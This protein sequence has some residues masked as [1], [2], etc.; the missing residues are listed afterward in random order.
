[1][2]SAQHLSGELGRDGGLRVAASFQQGR[3]AALIGIGEQTNRV[4]Q[5]FEAAQ[6]RPAGDRAQ[7]SQRKVEIARTL[8][9]RRID[10]PQRL[11]RDHEAGEDAGLAQQPLEALMRRGFPAFE[12]A[13]CV[14]IDARRF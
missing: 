7:R 3:Q 9:A 8:A 2:E 13:A 5:Q 11:V 14:R 6:H 10:Q 4:E 1:M 12:R